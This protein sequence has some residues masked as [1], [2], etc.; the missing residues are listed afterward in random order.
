MS[1]GN[2]N[3][4]FGFSKSV[5]LYLTLV[6]ATLLS[7]GCF[8]SD[9]RNPVEDAESNSPDSEIVERDAKIEINAQDSGRVRDASRRDAGSIDSRQ[10]SSTSRP[11]RGDGSTSGTRDADS[12]NTD[13]ETSGVETD[14]SAQDADDAELVDANNQSV[15]E[16]DA[17]STIDNKVC[18]DYGLLVARD[19]HHCNSGINCS[20]EASALRTSPCDASSGCIEMHCEGIGSSEPEPDTCDCV[21]SC[22]PA[23]RG[24]CHERWERYAGCI[25]SFCEGC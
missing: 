11:S 8:A 5:C 20:A 2:C 25:I 4:L 14:S 1:L 24:E 3:A 18:S 16:T 12:S 13:A 22:L 17:G 6:L 23:E 21:A 15:S 7:V 9:K 10:D 19:C